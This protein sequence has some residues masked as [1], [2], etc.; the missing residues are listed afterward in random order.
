MEPVS[1]PRGFLGVEHI[2]IVTTVNTRCYGP[3]LIHFRYIVT[4]QT[5]HKAICDETKEYRQG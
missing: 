2:E 5:P 3:Y 4:Y 1:T